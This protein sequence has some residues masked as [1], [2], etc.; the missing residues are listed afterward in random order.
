VCCMP[1]GVCD[2]TGIQCISSNERE[3]YGTPLTGLATVV[4]I[5]VRSCT[6]GMQTQF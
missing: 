4:S 1:L 5:M 2:M 3:S 6:V